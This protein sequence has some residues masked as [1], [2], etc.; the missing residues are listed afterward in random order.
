MA[1]GGSYIDAPV[2]GR[3]GIAGDWVLPAGGPEEAIKYVKPVLNT[4]AKEIIRVGENGSGNSFKLLN[5]LMFSVINGISTEVMA[6]TGILGID[7]KKFYEVICNSGAATV[8]GLFIETAG[9]IVEDRF[10]EPT[11]TLELLCKD[12]DLG[13]RMVK[14]AGAYPL[15]SGFVQNLNENA[16]GVGLAKQDTSSIFKIFRNYY[17]KLDL[18]NNK[19]EGEIKWQK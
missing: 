3:P 4:F 2:L 5:Q 8:S 17:S 16:K 6:L 12:A 13:I 11:F 18:S 14:N 7:S 19:K 15:I 1:E 9:R 10:Y